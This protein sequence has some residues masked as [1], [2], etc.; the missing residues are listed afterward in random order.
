MKLCGISFTPF[1]INT[2]SKELKF[3]LTPKIIFP[4]IEKNIKN[5]I[6]Y[7]KLRAFRSNE[8][9]MDCDIADYNSSLA[10]YKSYAHKKISE[11][12]P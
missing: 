9:N 8:E 11:I 10:S 5:F 6:R 1:K 2:L 3:T 12:L 4:K 7:L